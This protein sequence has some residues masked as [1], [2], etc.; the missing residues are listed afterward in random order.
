[1]GRKKKLKLRLE[2]VLKEKGVTKYGFAKLL[3]KSTSN[4]AIYFRKDYK[5][6]LS[7]LEKWAEVLDCK[8]SDFFDE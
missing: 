3:N 4:V 5:P 2:D 7:T 8:I 1:M 6:N